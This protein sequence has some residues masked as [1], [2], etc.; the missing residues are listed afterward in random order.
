MPL[1]IRHAS[2]EDASVFQRIARH[3]SLAD[4]F[5]SFQDDEE[6]ASDLLHPMVAQGLT[7]IAW[8]DD[9]PVG[10]V[11]AY[12]VR[13]AGSPGW[14]FLRLGV[15]GPAR[16]RGIGTGLL[17]TVARR[18]RELDVLGAGGELLLPT[19]AASD[20]GH[21]FAARLG[22]VVER[23]FWHMKR[24]AGPIAAPEWPD[25]I[26]IHV[27]DWSDRMF[28][29]WNAIYEASFAEHYRPIP[30]TPDLCRRI[31]E[32]PD[33]LRDGLALAYRG[34]RCVGFCRNEQSAGAGVIGLLGVSPELRGRGLGRALLRWGVAYF[35]EPRWKW[36]QL[37]VDGVNEHATRLY[38]SEGFEVDRERRIHRGAVDALIAG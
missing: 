18:A 22:F 32:A 38:R 37:G 6:A 10:F 34:E 33:F 24:P 9:E 14:V 31:A 1:E 5:E 20:A 30:S 15:A 7:H 23:Y 12:G 35:A 11:A 4:Y 8:L 16:R 3:P 26:T 28:D 25:G 36:V 2:A 17:R 19:D 13:P 21:A 27:F 29:D